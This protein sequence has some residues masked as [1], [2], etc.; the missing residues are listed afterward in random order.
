MYAVFLVR[1]PDTFKKL[2]YMENNLTKE[3]FNREIREANSICILGHISPDGDCVGSVLGTF[4][5]IC[6]LKGIKAGNAEAEEDRESGKE[7]AVLVQPYLEEVNDKFLYLK[8]SDIVC[9]DP[10]DDRKY[11]LAI[12][13]DC[14]DEDRL[15]RFRHFMDH[16]QK[17]LMI[18]H[19]YTN[20]GF[21][22]YMFVA[23]NASSA[24]E[25]LFGMMEEAYVNKDIAECIYT[26]LI[27]DTGVFRHNSTSPKTL[28]AA[29]KCME[30]GIN[31]NAIIE[32]SFFSMTLR[33]KR[34]L[35]WILTHMEARLDG[36]LIIA[37]IDMKTR[38]ELDAVE[39][40]MDGMIDQMRTTTGA[41]LAAYIY[42]TKDHRGKLS[43]RSNSDLVDVSRIAANY[44]GG[45]HKRAAGCFMGLDFEK[46]KAEIE[47]A[48]L[49]Q[50]NV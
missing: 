36:R 48:V 6:S 42:E 40:D 16:A 25:V 49:E 39:M 1:Q 41:L 24:C 45:G 15:G 18:D 12:V 38:K 19:H 7:S 26:G 28:R 5:Y 43:L 2:V 9:T 30:Y 34:V 50:L 11:E 29:A 33:Q 4:N 20:P 22:D 23:S 32:E 27:H 35:G 46:D 47:L 14:G 37:C 13:C 44:G 3:I 31:F 10:K 8:G 21:G 17:V